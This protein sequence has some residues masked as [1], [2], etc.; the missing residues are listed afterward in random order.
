MY[1]I[2]HQTLSPVGII[3]QTE[4]VDIHQRQSKFTEAIVD[5]LTIKTGV[6][7]ILQTENKFFPSCC[8]RNGGLA[9]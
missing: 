1:T 6:I 3:L 7:H 2:S 9:A 8:F 5:I 4:G